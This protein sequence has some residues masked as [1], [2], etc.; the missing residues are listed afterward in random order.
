MSCSETMKCRKVRRVLRYHVPNKNRYPGKFAHHLLLMSYPF[1]LE[2]ELLTG[3]PPI[4]QITLACPSMLN[5]VNKNWQKF[6]PYDEIS[7][8]AF[9]NINHN[10]QSN[11]DSY[12]QIENDKTEV[13]S[14]SYKNKNASNVNI[15]E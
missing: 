1:R 4:Y 9:A 5:A 8:A 10:L 3:N 11:Q 15:N 12:G 2:D 14:F 7:K 6:E 13:T